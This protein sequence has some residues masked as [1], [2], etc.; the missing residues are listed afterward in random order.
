MRERV[1]FTRDFVQKCPYF[2][3]APDHYDPKAFQKS[4]N[5]GTPDHL[6]TLI[7]EI[8][9]LENPEKE[10]YE[11]ALHRAAKALDVA[12]GSLIHSARLAVSGMGVGPGLYDI[13]SILGKEET[14]RRIRSA[15]ERL[16]S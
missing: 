3:Q 8:S 9:G 5:E 13:L 15:I 14:I 2:F 1:T 6:A 4:W 10:D 12:H 16:K 7:E 11:A